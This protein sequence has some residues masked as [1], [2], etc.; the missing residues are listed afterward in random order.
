MRQSVR[1]HQ[2]RLPAMASNLPVLWIEKE[3][4]EAL[5]RPGPTALVPWVANH[6]WARFGEMVEYIPANRCRTCRFFEP[7]IAALCSYW[8][9]AVKADGSDFCSKWKEKE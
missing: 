1:S 2:E 6:N 8:Q 4:V 7:G 3:I 5:T 9:G